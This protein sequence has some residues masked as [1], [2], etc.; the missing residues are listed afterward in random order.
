MFSLGLATGVYRNKKGGITA[1]VLAKRL[2]VS[3]S[4]VTLMESG[5]RLPPLKNEFI[6]AA[7]N[8][9]E[10]PKTDVLG[11]VVCEHYFASMKELAWFPSL[12]FKAISKRFVRDYLHETDE[13]GG[14]IV[15]VLS[16]ADRFRAP[17]LQE[18]L[19]R[20][21]PVAG[22]FYRLEKEVTIAGKKMPVIGMFKNAKSYLYQSESLFP[23]RDSLLFMDSFGIYDGGRFHFL[24]QSP[25]T[26]ETDDGQWRTEQ[27]CISPY[28]SEPI[29]SIS[30]PM[31]QF[32]YDK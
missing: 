22:D 1:D 19:A 31:T 30:Y 29:S 25:F 24:W 20:L 16:P 23:L 8:F 13:D 7:A 15:N 5:Q 27:V 9:L 11:S 28:A 14:M 2:G 26:G 6:E 12:Y 18:L 3:R 32:S 21:H 10:T 17:L 4:F